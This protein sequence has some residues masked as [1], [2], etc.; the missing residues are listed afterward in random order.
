MLLITSRLMVKHS[1]WDPDGVR[2]FDLVCA[3][4]RLNE[5]PARVGV[6]HTLYG[7]AVVARRMTGYQAC[8]GD[9]RQIRGA[10]RA[11]A[12]NQSMPLPRVFA[13]TVS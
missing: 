11:P 8:T 13:S 9:L 12:R 2:C 10:C 3:V 4:L 7:S 1:C 5:A 6:E